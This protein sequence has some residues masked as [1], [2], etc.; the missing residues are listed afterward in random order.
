MLSRNDYAHGQD[1][2]DVPEVGWAVEYWD[3]TE[4]GLLKRDP[5]TN[6]TLMTE[7]KAKAEAD[8][9]RARGVEARAVQ[10]EGE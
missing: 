2:R 3:G 6:R 1:D 7:K 10:V 9:I 5:W 8:D 4:W